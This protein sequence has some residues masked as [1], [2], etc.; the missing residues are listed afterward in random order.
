[1]RAA[2]LRWYKGFGEYAVLMLPRLGSCAVFRKAINEKGLVLGPC[3]KN[4]GD[5]ECKVRCIMAR[6]RFL[7]ARVYAALEACDSRRIGL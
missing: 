1:M 4:G 5:Y 3:V 6:A 2:H 7:V